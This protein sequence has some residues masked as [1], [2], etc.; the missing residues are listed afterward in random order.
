MSIFMKIFYI[1]YFF[2]TNNVQ[3][4]FC[5]KHFIFLSSSFLPAPVVYQLGQNKVLFV[6]V[7]CSCNGSRI[8]LPIV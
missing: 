2:V 3:R 7:V 4:L 6:F 1:L 8:V 5:N